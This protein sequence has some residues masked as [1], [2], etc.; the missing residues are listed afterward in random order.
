MLSSFNSLAPPVAEISAVYWF[1]LVN[2]QAK[3]QAI[4]VYAMGHESESD[5]LD[6]WSF[7]FFFFSL[8]VVTLTVDPMYLSSSNIVFFAEYLPQ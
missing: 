4:T 2:K 6:L 3:S 7:F 5:D 8:S 1:C